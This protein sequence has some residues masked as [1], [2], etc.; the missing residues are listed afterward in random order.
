MIFHN[1]RVIFRGRIWECDI[2]VEDGKIIDIRKVIWGRGKDIRGRYVFFNVTDMHTHMRDWEQKDKETV[3]TGTRAALAG[4][5]TR[6]V[7]MPN[8]NPPVQ[9]VESYR[10][11]VALFRKKSYCDFRINL[12]AKSSR[13]ISS[14]TKTF[15][16]PFIKIYLSHTTGDYLFTGSLDALFAQGIPIAVHGEFEDIRKCVSLSKKYGTP[17]HV[18]HIASR[19]EIEFLSKKK[20]P[21]LTIEVTP[22]HLLCENH[23]DVKPP[24]GSARDRDAL[25]SNSHAI[26]VIASDHAPHTPADKQRGAFGYSGVEIMLP[27]MLD[28]VNKK[29][30]SLFDVAYRISET[31]A[32]LLGEKEFETGAPANFC[33]LDMEKEWRIDASRFVSKG[34]ATPFDGR[35]IRGRVAQTFLHGE[36]VFDGENVFRCNRQQ[37]R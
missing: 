22:H 4:G 10:K 23:S 34:K 32:R 12:G 21:G 26:D 18:C 6:I 35:E 7:D 27:L 16:P 17:L 13:K 1:M 2:E 30:L 8:T 31:P 19:G 25:W 14:F 36:E 11:R 9:D 28:C 29:L 24:V 3:E 15:N 37:K 20:H 5:I 33:I